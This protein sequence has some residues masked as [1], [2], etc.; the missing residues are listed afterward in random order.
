[1]R[2]R[3]FVACAVLLVAVAGLTQAEEKLDVDYKADI[4]YGNAAGE[5]LKL[6][7]ASPKGLDHPVPAIV[8]IH[9]GGWAQGKRQD[10]AGFARQAAAHGY[11]AAT[12]SYRLAPKHRYPA[13]IEDVKCAV[14]YL[15]ANA[16][17]LN[18][19]PARIG[20]TGVSAG[21]HLSMMLGFMD[22]GDGMDGSGGNPDQSSKVQCVV[23][24]VGPVDLVRDDYSE[25][26]TRILE[27]FFGGKPK[28]KQAECKAASPVTYINKGDAPTLCFFGTKDPLVSYDQAFQITDVLAKNEV[29]GRVELLLGAGH[30]WLGPEMTR[31]ID[32]MLAFFDQHLK[33]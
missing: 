32:G 4:V 22:S 20:A 9:G 5:E 26:S 25:T 31:T 27:N 16:K 23:N 13:A 8:V 3:S 10:M 21:G 29:T 19:D 33:K 18:I 24:F 6:D 2:S 7:L 11:V 12:V 1:M 17:E 28:D 30:G 15:R 14:R